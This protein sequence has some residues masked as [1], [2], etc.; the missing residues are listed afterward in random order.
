MLLWKT[1]SKV[2]DSFMFEISIVPLSQSITGLYCF[3]QGSPRIMS[4]LPMSVTRKSSVHFLV[5]DFD[6]QPSRVF[7]FPGVVLCAIDIIDSYRVV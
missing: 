3:S 7:D 6:F 1:S 4:S 2:F 5:V